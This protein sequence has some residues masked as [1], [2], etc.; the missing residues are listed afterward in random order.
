MHSLHA[1]L[2]VHPEMHCFACDYPPRTDCTSRHCLS[3]TGCPRSGSINLCLVISMTEQPAAITGSHALHYLLLCCC[4]QRCL[5]TD[6]LHLHVTQAPQ[7]SCAHSLHGA[8]I[9]SYLT[10][11]HCVD[12]HNR[13]TLITSMSVCLC[14]TGRERHNVVKPPFIE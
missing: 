4:T 5:S 14:L 8:G 9:T 7:I 2:I 13:V 12:E 6:H 11:K 3:E 10:C 1:R